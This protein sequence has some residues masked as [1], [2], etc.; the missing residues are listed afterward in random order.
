MY[1]IQSNVNSN[2]NVS[3]RAKKPNKGASK[4]FWKK[5]KQKALDMLPSG[6]HNDSKKTNDKKQNIDTLLSRPEINR[7]LMG[8]TA[9]ITQPAIDMANYDVNKDT[10]E[11]ARNRTIAKII[12]GTCVGILVRGGCYRLVAKMTKTN[13][14][15][16]FEKA[17]IPI[18]KTEEFLKNETYQKNYR[19]EF[20]NQVNDLTNILAKN[21]NGSQS[22]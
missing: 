17:L 20:H 3:M 1:C 14:K 4:S 10:R 6:T 11:V 15:S 16:A 13:A 22:L 2:Y 21:S 12:A 7:A 9:M 5:L 19:N 18:V 8:A